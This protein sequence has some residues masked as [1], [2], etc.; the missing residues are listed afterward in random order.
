MMAL[1]R[2]PRH[3]P[4]DLAAWD[5]LERED[6][7]RSRTETFREQ[8]RE[9]LNT[10]RDF[11]ACNP[12]YVSVSWGKDS[13]V[14]AHLARA[15]QEEE[16]IELPLVW[17]REDPPSVPYCTEVRDMF[18]FRWPIRI[19]HEEIVDI[20]GP[21]LEA[22]PIWDAALKRIGKRYGQGWIGGL[23]GEESGQRARRMALGL[24]LRYSC[25][26]LGRWTAQ[27]VFAYLRAHDLPVHPNYAMSFGGSLDRGRLRVG[28]VSDP[29]DRSKDMG[30]RRGDEFGRA[31]SEAAYYPVVR[32]S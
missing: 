27:D 16:G 21:V 3:R 23:R 13:T 9:A 19:Y 10:M 22:Q 28:A 6:E 2:V 31:E 30:G 26:P 20:T 7:I 25:Q 8:C 11:A 24:S 29:G 5:R 32:D 17:I 1:I 4:E 14:V 12:C 18:L 15:L